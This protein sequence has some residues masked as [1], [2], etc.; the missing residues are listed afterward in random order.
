M[1]SDC[2]AGRSPGATE[3]VAAGLRSRLGGGASGHL[4]FPRSEVRPAV[5]SAADGG[6][7]LWPSN[8]LVT[9]PSLNTSLIARA[10]SGA[11]DRTVSFSNRFSLVIGSVLQTIPSLM[12]ELFSMSTA[13]PDSTP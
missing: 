9:D 8:R 4:L 10:I 3:L 11:I 12:R 13:V 6:R 7:Q 1:P 5:S 2:H